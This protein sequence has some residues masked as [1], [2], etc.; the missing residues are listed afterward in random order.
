VGFLEQ[1]VGHAF[2]Y[3]ICIDSAPLLER[4]LAQRAGLGW[5]GRNTCLIHPVIGSWFFLAEVLLGIEMEPDPPFTADRCG[6]CTRCIESCPTGALLPDRTLDARRCIAYLTIENKGAIPEE[7]RSR[8]GAWIFG[9]DVCQ[10]ACPWNHKKS[11]VGDPAFEPHA[12]I[13]EMEPCSQMTLTPDEFKSKFKESPVLRARRSGYLRNIAVMLGNHGSKDAVL[14]LE[15][16]LKDEDVLVREHA[17]WA[18]EK[19]NART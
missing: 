17:A 3:R 6:N 16:A 2:P 9:C 18:L 19:I 8:M 4:D 12:G 14:I 15:Q 5:I 1:Q 7:L 11:A 13:L 10:M